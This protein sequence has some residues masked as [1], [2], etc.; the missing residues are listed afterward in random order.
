LEPDGLTEFLPDEEA[1]AAL[2]RLV[3]RRVA[4]RSPGSGRYHALSRLVQH[5][6]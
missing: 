2:D 3:D 1:R 4:F 6:L 5:L